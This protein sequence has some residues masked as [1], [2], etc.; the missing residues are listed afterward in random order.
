MATSEATVVERFRLGAMKVQT[1]VQ[2]V[3]AEVLQVVECIPEGSM[4]DCPLVQVA[5]TV[6]GFG[7]YVDG[8]LVWPV[9]SEEN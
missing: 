7:V 3:D 5:W 1:A 9:E 4:S 8:S 6:D 2:V